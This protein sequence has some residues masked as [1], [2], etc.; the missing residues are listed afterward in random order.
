M[1]GAKLRPVGCLSDG[2]QLLLLTELDQTVNKAASIQPAD[3]LPNCS[4]PMVGSSYIMKT[5]MTREVLL[6][7]NCQLVNAALIHGCR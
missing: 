6:W 3:G 4:G 1:N 2:R 7:G 5:G